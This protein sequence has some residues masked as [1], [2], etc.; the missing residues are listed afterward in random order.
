MSPIPN[1]PKNPKRWREDP[2]PAGSVLSCSLENTSDNSSV[3]LSPS[4]TALQLQTK[5]TRRLSPALISFLTSLIF[6]TAFLIVLALIVIRGLQG[7]NSH[8]QLEASIQK[9]S[10]SASGAL[11]AS[12]VISPPQFDEQKSRADQIAGEDSNI[13]KNKANA[14]EIGTVQRYQPEQEGAQNVAYRLQKS[15]AELAM[16]STAKENDSKDDGSGKP[17]EAT[18]FGAKAYGNRFVFIIDASTSMEGYRWNRAVGELLKC[19]G[20]LA[21]GAEFFIIAFHFEPVPIDLSRATTK[22]F[23]VKGNG[24]VVLCRKWLHSIILA[25]RTMPASSLELA[26]DFEPDAIFLLSDG[27]IRDNSLALLRDMNQKDDKPIVPINTIHLFSNEGK[28]TLETLARENGGS[29]TAV[30]GKD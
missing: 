20:E 29:F 19:I 26:L 2:E 6:H 14:D 17:G 7:S 21:D 15:V 12:V 1:H 8:V 13:E 28:E 11:L 3:E 5:P 10:D 25:P 9:E 22:T 30:G 4:S 16:V 27:E 23:L 24:S 18:F